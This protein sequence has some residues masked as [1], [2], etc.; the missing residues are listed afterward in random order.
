LTGAIVELSAATGENTREVSTRMA[1]VNG[2][3]AGVLQL[4]A[5][6]SRYAE[7]I[8]LHLGD[9]LSGGVRDL[10]A[11]NMRQSAPR[12]ATPEA[13]TAVANDPLPAACVLES[14]QSGQ[15]LDEIKLGRVDRFVPSRA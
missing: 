10:E 12:E 7:D 13:L 14:R 2:A 3:A 5:D 15:N 1:E 9:M 6:A 11:M 4:S 8:A